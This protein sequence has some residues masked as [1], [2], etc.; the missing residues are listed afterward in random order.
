M[1]ST[2]LELVNEGEWKKAIALLEQNT[3]H[4][5]ILTVENGWLAFGYFFMGQCDD[6]SKQAV[7]S[8]AVYDA[9]KA[10][11]LP[12]ID[13]VSPAKKSA[14]EANSPPATKESVIGPQGDPQIVATVI[15]A[16][17][18]L[19]RSKM[20]D[21]AAELALLPESTQKN[22]LVN[23]AY[24]ALK[25]REN[26]ANE[27]IG[28][29][30]RCVDVAPDFAWGYRTMGRIAQNALKD[31]DSADLAYSKALAVEPKFDTV[32][33]ALIEIRLGRNDFDGAVQVETDALRLDPANADY[34]YRLAQIFAQQY[35]YEEALKQLEIAINGQPDNAKFYRARAGIKRN[36]NKLARYQ[37]IIND[38]IADMQKAVD[39]SK[40]K[41]FELVELAAMN[42][43]AGN[44]NR[45]ADNLQE[46]LKLDPDN[47]AAHDK[48]V[49]LLTMEKRYDDLVA[50]WKRT[51]ERKP[52]DAGARL[53][54]A[55]AYLAANN[56]DD[57]IKQFVQAANLD[58]RNAEP[59]RQMGAIRFR[60]KNYRAAAN[61][62]TTALNINPSSV[63]DLVALGYAYARNDD[64][65]QAEAAF[66]TAL[67]LQQ[68]TQANNPTSTPAR[69]E[70]TRA[71]AEL[72]FREQ[73]Y[74]EAAAQ[75]ETVYVAS[76]DTVNGPTDH[77]LLL[78]AKALRDLSQASAQAMIDAFQQLG[79]HQQTE[80][81]LNLIDALLDA[82]KSELASPFIEEAQK[83]QSEDK[84]FA[85]RVK[86]AAA[87]SLLVQ[88]K[89][90]QAKEMI[91]DAIPSLANAGV[92]PDETVRASQISNELLIASQIDLADHDL[93][94]ADSYARKSAEAY[95]KNFK[96]YIQI[97]RVA[98]Q[99]NK[100]K[101]AVAWARKALD[102]NQYAPEAYVVVGDGDLATGNVKDASA[103][104][105]RAAELYPG[106]I[107]AHRSLLETLRK[108]GKADEAKREE[109]QIAQME[110]QK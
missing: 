97:G 36:Q 23:F 51:V 79:P 78:Q 54:L 98:L 44:T 16:Y 89:A 107:E 30:Q 19:C 83:A 70:L 4:R 6:L 95:A 72:L 7:T 52:K 65:V 110:K 43:E 42:Q 1:S 48:L 12:P 62:Y 29:V 56:T 109:E 34:H 75:L 84:D 38:A 39:L 21:A 106:L 71:L 5:D 13:A 57:A 69:L 8:Q 2:V 105:R 100:P 40:D 99:Q 77:Y 74:S 46:A 32:R 33:E 60:Q 3:S 68:L 31:Y 61:E 94:T 102:I 88:G 85:T 73:R 55:M 86:F 64:Y 103:N 81:R 49:T 87:R 101:E 25:S 24:A 91:A 15:Q 66:V 50:E 11:K 93:A 82:N 53:G 92:A 26:R 10:A 104:F 47:T 63:P 108:L 14:D 76:K 28:Y 41:P 45:A 67:A 9:R 96:A 58:P 20:S 22:V 35:R 27:A 18:S 80:L 37:G 90:K 59:H 17:D